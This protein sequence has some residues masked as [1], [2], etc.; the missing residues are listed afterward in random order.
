MTADI[1]LADAITGL[2]AEKRAVGYKYATEARVLARFEGFCRGEF[3]GLGA[4]TQ[5]SVE[6]W[7]ASARRRG[8]KPATLQGLA[9][10]V[11]ELARWLGR[12]GAGAYILP[13]DV[14][15]RPARYAP[16]IYT[17]QELAALFA[18]TDRCHYC[19]QAPPGTRL[20]QAE[21]GHCRAS[22]PC[23]GGTG[24][25]AALGLRKSSPRTGWRHSRPW[26]W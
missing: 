21:P 14:L 23:W 5:V 17:D 6:A 7:V 3:P 4:V 15:A 18:R 20:R 11:R 19:S 25:H 24:S 9:A 12:R 26:H 1:T 16:H 2:I 10:P 22:T 13:G 8:V